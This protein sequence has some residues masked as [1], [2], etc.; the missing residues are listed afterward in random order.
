MLTV[1]ASAIT[2]R[3]GNSSRELYCY[4]TLSKTHSSGGGLGARASLSQEKGEGL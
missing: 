4:T 2:N 1:V 3:I